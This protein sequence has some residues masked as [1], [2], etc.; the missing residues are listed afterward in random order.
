MISAAARRICAGL[1]FVLLLTGLAEAQPASSPDALAERFEDVLRTNQN[2]RAFWGLI[3]QDLETGQVLYEQNADHAFL[4]ASN[5]KI[6]TVATA[7]DA[8][9]STFRYETTLTFDGTVDGA[10]MRGDLMI[11]GSGDPTFGS[12][13]M[14]GED[15][16]QTWAQKLAR[17]G[18]E[19]VE[20]RLIGNDNVFD[21]RAYAEGWDIDYVTEQA[22]RYMG[23]SV[24]G[25]A[26]HDNV[27]TLRIQSSTPGQP[28][29]VSTR[30]A[31][32][33]TIRNNATTSSRRR[34]D[35]LAV[36]RT[37]QS[38]DII[39]EGS[40][41]RDYQGSVVVPVN[42]PT[43]LTLEAF[44]EALHEVDIETDL[45][46][47]DIDELDTPPATDAPPLFV[48][49]SPPLSE[50]LSLLNKESNNFYAEQVF[51]TYG[52]AGS[53]RGGAR[54]TKTFLA[55]A[56]IDTRPLLIHDGSGLS[57]KDLIT[58]R[59]MVNLL[60]YMDRH[61]EREAFMAS[62]PLGGEPGTTLRYRLRNV[63]VR[64]KTGSLRFTRALSGYAT[65][66]DGRRV[67]F[68]FFANNYT[69]PSYRI[70]NLFDE[71][72]TMITTPPAS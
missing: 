42:N 70:T 46:L 58:P 9:G 43:L 24:G 21:N 40:T 30:P 18:V 50:I 72:V 20:G 33:V 53:A 45:T 36:N 37:F 8:L 65:R 66:P 38:N 51:R 16:L 64:A 35:G 1:T 29:S 62:L 15:P 67:A 47:I 57:R 19:R 61:R 28:P 14:R 49:L 12:R 68:S 39:I 34:G 55:R 13:E 59:A 11:N 22:G 4:P 31:N 32:V 2:S 41:P 6:L 52:W 71:L 26:Y 44:R 27:V 5:Q 17:M 3:V 63:P 10:V 56:G 23:T 54:R 25:L 7:L 69:G 48:A 60:A